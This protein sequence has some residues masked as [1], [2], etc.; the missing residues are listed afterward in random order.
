M[1]G[2]LAEERGAGLMVVGLA[3]AVGIDGCRERTHDGQTQ[4]PEDKALSGRANRLVIMLDVRDVRNEVVLSRSPRGRAARAASKCKPPR[5][6]CCGSLQP[7]VLTSPLPPDT[8][9]PSV[10]PPPKKA[11]FYR[12]TP[13]PPYSRPRQ[14]PHMPAVKAHWKCWRLPAPA[15]PRAG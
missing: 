6:R 12:Q 14:W 4:L 3:L 8:R 1:L 7:I 11:A 13:L 2:V 15:G 10:S 5:L 9:A